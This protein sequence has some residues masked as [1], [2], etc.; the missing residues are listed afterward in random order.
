MSCHTQLAMATLCV[1]ACPRARALVRACVYRLGWMAT[2]PLAVSC[3]HL[4]SAG[5]IGAHHHACPFY[6]EAK[7]QTQ[8]LLLAQQALYRRGSP[9]PCPGSF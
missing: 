4:P 5:I 8:V 9:S 6:M 3:P 1:C 7:V 2:K